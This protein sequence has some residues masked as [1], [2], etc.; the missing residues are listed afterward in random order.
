M[1][2]GDQ[3]LKI[4]PGIAQYWWSHQMY[5]S[6]R[7]WLVL[8]LF[9]ILDWSKELRGSNTERKVLNQRHLVEM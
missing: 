8:R 2:H 3:C 4:K 7:Q 6:Y 1:F 9:P 5:D